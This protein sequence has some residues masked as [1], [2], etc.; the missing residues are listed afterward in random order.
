MPDRCF[1]SRVWGDLTW[2]R[3]SCLNIPGRQS[4]RVDQT[5]KL[6]RKVQVPSIFWL[7]WTINKIN[8][9]ANPL[10]AVIKYSPMI[11]SAVVAPPR[12]K[13]KSGWRSLCIESFFCSLKFHK[14]RYS[15]DKI[16]KESKG[17][18]LL[19]LWGQYR[20]LMNFGN[21]TWLCFFRNFVLTTRWV[22]GVRLSEKHRQ[23]C[24]GIPQQQPHTGFVLTQ[25]NCWPGQKNLS[26]GQC[27]RLQACRVLGCSF[28]F[29][30]V[31]LTR[32]YPRKFHILKNFFFS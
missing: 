29:T 18:V 7:K 16:R 25:P 28:V 27:V 32:V 15:L 13:S 9:A 12:K 2:A 3:W 11:V 4:V 23:V 31:C 19:F 8:V 20:W 30:E 24:T 26:T 10:A 21:V 1:D 6:D 17:L 5:P 14:E 22:F